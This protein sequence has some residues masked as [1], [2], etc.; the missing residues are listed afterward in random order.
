MGY[1]YIGCSMAYTIDH[2]IM[3]ITMK[4]ILL[5]I[6]FFLLFGTMSFMGGVKYGRTV[7]ISTTPRVCECLK[8]DTTLIEFH[9]SYYEKHCK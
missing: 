5:I 6:I 3:V 1:H 4:T 2:Y 8:S 7:H 9:R